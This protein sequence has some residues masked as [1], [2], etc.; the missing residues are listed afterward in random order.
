MVFLVKI[1]EKSSI[2]DSHR[3]LSEGR[4][5][6]LK[7]H[8]IEHFRRPSKCTHCKTVKAVHAVIWPRN[9]MFG[10]TRPSVQTPDDWE[11]FLSISRVFADRGQF[12]IDFPLEA[13]RM[14]WHHYKRMHEQLNHKEW[15]VGSMILLSQHCWK[16]D[17]MMENFILPADPTSFETIPQRCIFSA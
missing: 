9:G 11:V 3:L 13:C 2:S 8:R 1:L 16:Q 15:P 12:A 7:Y 14:L 6:N 17:I 10:V 4:C 5:T